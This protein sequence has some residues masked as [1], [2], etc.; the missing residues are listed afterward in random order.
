MPTPGKLKLILAAA[1]CCLGGSAAAADLLEVY[2][3]AVKADP[4]VRA[5][6]DA[7]L[8]EFEAKPQARSLLLP[9]VNFTAEVDR[10][11][12]HI[13]ESS[14]GERG[15]F[16]YNSSALGLSLRQPLYNGDYFAQ[17]RQADATLGRADAQY[18]AA[19]QALITRVSQAYFNLLAARDNLTFV[20][21]QKN[22][23]GQQLEQTRKRFDVGLIAITDVHVAQAAFDLAAAQEIEAVNA[24]QSSREALFEIT[25]EYVDDVNPLTRDIPLAVPDPTDVDQWV[26]A[27]IK[28]NFDL[29]AAQFNEQLAREEVSRQRTGH[30]PTLDLVAGITRTDIGNGAPQETEGDDAVVGLQLTL[31]LYEGNA[32]R[33]RTRQAGY[34]L[35]QAMEQV[36]SQRRAT[37]RQTRDAYNAVIAAINRVKALEQARISARS[38]LEATEAGFEV[39]TRTAVDVLAARSD[40]F[41]ADSNYARA[42]YDYVV[43]TLLLK[44]AS[45]SLSMADLEEI[46]SHLAAA[47]ATP[48]PAPSAAPPASP[49]VTP[50]AATH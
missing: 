19:Q 47:P 20:Q 35:A 1:L 5:A 14:V 17:L 3:L 24:L 13:T 26:E 39:G 4:V 31:P 43:N 41:E 10:N 48:T 44:Q 7:R 12:D 36:E 33:S 50:P 18:N 21:A 8:A 40:L 29:L 34:L 32:V 2:R 23:I 37:L 46:N 6:E 11:R 38:A 16:N 22:A 45:G 28:Q 9:F 25:G 15:T 30:Y 27:A 49:P 42:R